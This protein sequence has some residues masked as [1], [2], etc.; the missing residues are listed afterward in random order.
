MFSARINQDRP[1]GEHIRVDSSPE[2]CHQA[3]DRSL[4]RLGLR[5]V[6][7]YYVYRLDKTTPVEKTIEAM[8]ELKRAGKIKYLGAASLIFR[9]LVAN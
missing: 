8:V 5:Y 7:L 2:Y 4:S 1:V 9:P 3:I 6:D